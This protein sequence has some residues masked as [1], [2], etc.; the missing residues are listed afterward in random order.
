[1]VKTGKP[2]SCL[3]AV[4]MV[5]ATW[6]RI[7]GCG[8]DQQGA[9]LVLHHDSWHFKVG[10]SR[11]KV[12]FCGSMLPCPPGH[13][14]EPELPDA[15]PQAMLFLLLD[16]VL[17]SLSILCYPKSCSHMPSCGAPPRHQP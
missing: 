10:G 14:L 9:T 7:P 12:G 16:L 5:R 17:Q 2:R 3:V 11:L 15:G 1:M 8:Q 6:E 13:S 4:V